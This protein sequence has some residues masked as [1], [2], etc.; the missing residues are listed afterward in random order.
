MFDRLTHFEILRR[1]KKRQKNL[2]SSYTALDIPWIK[3]V[4]A[5]IMTNDQTKKLCENHTQ[6][7]KH[8]QYQKMNQS[9]PE[10]WVKQ[11][12]D[13][14]KIPG[15][16]T[17]SDILK[18]KENYLG[19]SPEELSCKRRRMA[20]HPEPDTTLANWVS[21]FEH[22]RTRLN[23]PL[24]ES[25]PKPLAEKMN[26]S[27]EG[28]LVFY[29]GW[30]KSFQLQ[31]SFQNLKTHSESGSADFTVIQQSLPEIIGMKNKFS[32]K[33]WFNMDETGLLYCLTPDRKVESQ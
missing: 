30:L 28:K 8:T 7:Q 31:H 2:L 27:F 21:Q 15:Q 5:G 16:T 1:E 18:K 32:L 12:F 14:L 33:D 19:M 11:I 9:H 10:K 23:G 22:N 3:S 20:H 25:K 4:Q 24:I 17:I 13:L 26:I 6:C 29:R